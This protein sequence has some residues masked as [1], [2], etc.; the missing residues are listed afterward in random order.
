MRPTLAALLLS[1]FLPLPLAAQA[2]DGGLLR[3][4]GTAGVPAVPVQLVAGDTT[5]VDEG[6]TRADG[7]FTLAA[8]G[9]GSFRIVVHPAGGSGIVFGPVTLAAGERKPLLLR[10]PRGADQPVALAGI[11]ATAEQRRRLLDRH[12][13]YQRKHLYPGR[14]LT[15]DDFERLHGLRVVE[16]ILDLGLFMEPRGGSGFRLYRVQQGGRCYVA[17]YVD[18]LPVGDQ[19]LVL[20]KDDEVAGVEY[21]TRDDVPPEFNPY[22]GNPNWRCGSVVIW[23]QPP[24]MDAPPAAPQPSS[25]P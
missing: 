10:L 15:H 14:F 22:L 1:I 6:V 8:P 24:G 5:V 4:Q 20:L 19:P 12:G 2:I 9:A 3:A 16:K 13:F 21:Y 25:A 17:T 18:G 23:T 7:G 11:T